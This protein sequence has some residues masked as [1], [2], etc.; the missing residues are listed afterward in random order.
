MGHSEGAAHEP[1]VTIFNDKHQLEGNLP[2]NTG[3]WMSGAVMELYPAHLG[4][5]GIAFLIQN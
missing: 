4:R 5:D 3:L 1:K 2:P